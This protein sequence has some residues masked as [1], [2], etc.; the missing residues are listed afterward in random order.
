MQISFDNVANWFEGLLSGTKSREDAD[1]WAWQAM[2]AQD[3]GSLEFTPATDEQ[4]IWR[5]LTYLCGVDLLS[6]PGTYLHT[7]DDIRTAYQRIKDGQLE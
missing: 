6:A 7:A 2:Q 4:R 1:S 3:S 5:G